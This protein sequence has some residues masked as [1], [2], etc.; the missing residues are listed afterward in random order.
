MSRDL[1]L[2]VLCNMPMDGPFDA[3]RL[4]G[5]SEGEGFGS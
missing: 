3:R 4:S 1:F 5:E 2:E